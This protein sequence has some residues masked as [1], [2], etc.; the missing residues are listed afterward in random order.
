MIEQ[1]YFD[2]FITV[3]FLPV[4]MIV[5]GLPLAFICEIFDRYLDYKIR[6]KYGK[7]QNPLR[8]NYVLAQEKA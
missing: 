5:V 1:M 3:L 7:Q 2:V 4:L 6:K 8:N